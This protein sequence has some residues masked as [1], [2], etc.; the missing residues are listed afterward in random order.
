MTK[1]KFEVGKEYSTRS[2]KKA[3]VFEIN[4][5][6]FTSS[7]ILGAILEEDGRSEMASWGIDG[8]FFSNREFGSDLM[9]PEPEKRVM[10]VW[11]NIYPDAIYGPYTSKREA[12]CVSTKHALIACVYREI[13]YYVGEGLDG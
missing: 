5:K 8:R 12:D 3:K 7:K 13:K 10:K 4:E 6:N 9:P 11:F 2:G 1:C